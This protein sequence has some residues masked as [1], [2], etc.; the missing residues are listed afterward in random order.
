MSH[1]IVIKGG[2]IV[3]GTGAAPFAGDLAIDD[4]RIRH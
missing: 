1:E 3:D 2:T 4:G